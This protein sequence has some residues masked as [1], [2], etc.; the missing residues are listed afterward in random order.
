MA[1]VAAYRR[2]GYTVV[3]SVGKLRRMPEHL[4]DPLCTRSTSLYPTIRGF[5]PFVS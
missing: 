1:G 2:R 4:W 5:Y 3:D